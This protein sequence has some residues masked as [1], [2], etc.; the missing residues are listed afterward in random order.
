MSEV[1][2]QQESSTISSIVIVGVTVLFAGG[3]ISDLAP[4]L[5]STSENGVVTIHE[6]SKTIGLSNPLIDRHKDEIDFEQQVM[7]FY[8]DL[9]LEQESLSEEFEGVL[10]E[11]LW[12]LY[13][14]T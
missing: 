3:S 5:P 14:R 2:I 12:D 7:S 11:N 4:V 6:S 10:H 13:I 8:A 1:S 9:L